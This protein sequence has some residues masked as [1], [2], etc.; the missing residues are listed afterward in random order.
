MAHG[1]EYTMNHTASSQAGKDHWPWDLLEESNERWADAVR[2]E[3]QAGTLG[4]QAEKDQATRDKW[5]AMGDGQKCRDELTRFF[6]G[7]LRIALQ[8]QPE[9]LKT[10]LAEATTS[11][12]LK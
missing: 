7:G 10:L 1:L 11:T 4:Q 2:R 5:D 8:E 12:R 3:L 9:Q 6:L